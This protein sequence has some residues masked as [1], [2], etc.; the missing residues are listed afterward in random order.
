MIIHTSARRRMCS[1]PCKETVREETVKNYEQEVFARR[2]ALLNDLP[3]KLG[4]IDQ[5]LS[6]FALNP[7]IGHE[8][9]RTRAVEQGLLLLQQ[10]H[11]RLSHLESV[12]QARLKC[13]I[14]SPAPVMTID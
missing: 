9:N 14:N 3:D 7:C 10:A 11:G 13:V 1:K 4:S 6:T 5:G 2:K 12:I 8:G